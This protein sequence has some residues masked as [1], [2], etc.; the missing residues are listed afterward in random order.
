MQFNPAQTY[1][2]PTSIS[3]FIDRWRPHHIPGE[4]SGLLTSGVHTRFY[5][6]ITARA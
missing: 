4:F 1:L 5:F 6:G 3:A 2:R